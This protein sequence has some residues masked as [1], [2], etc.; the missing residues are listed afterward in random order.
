MN[1]KDI[2]NEI[3]DLFSWMNES[4]I[5]ESSKN[6]IK[7]LPET[8]SQHLEGSNN[9]KNCLKDIATDK[10][11]SNELNL[12]KNKNGTVKKLKCKMCNAKIGLLDELISTCKCEQKYCSKHRMP[13]L[14]KCVKLEEIGDEQRKNLKLSL[15]KVTSDNG[16]VKI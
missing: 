1:N 16:R 13:E 10:T 3:N 7:I 12:D 14:H 4:N 15:V 2:F 8:E 9:S 5:F 6:N 11:K